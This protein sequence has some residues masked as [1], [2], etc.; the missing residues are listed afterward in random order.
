MADLRIKV[1]LG[2]ILVVRYLQKTV[3]VEVED[4][5]DEKR[6]EILEKEWE[7]GKAEMK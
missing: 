6:E 4:S 5:D 3:D 2:Y 1:D 7:D